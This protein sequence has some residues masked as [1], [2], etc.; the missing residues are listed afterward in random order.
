MNN[1][2]L[3]G[4]LLS[5]S[6]LCLGC[7]GFGTARTAEES[8]A[9]LDSFTAL[10]GNFIDTAAIYGKWE[11]DGLSHSELTI[12]KWLKRRGSADGINVCTK[13]AHPELA[14]M[15]VPRMSR[16]DIESDVDDSLRHLGV[17]RISLLLLHRD[18]EE[19]PVEDILESLTAMVSAGKVAHFGCS[20]WKPGRMREM[21]EAAR[22]AD[23]AG[24]SANQVMWSLAGHD[25]DAIPH[26][27]CAM[28][29]GTYAFH[30]EASLT[31]MCYS[32]QARGYFPKLALGGADALDE[33]VRRTY[34]AERNAGIARI[35]GEVSAQT[36]HTVGALALAY[37]TCQTDFPAVPV[38]GS[39][40]TEQLEEC[41]ASAEIAL[42]EEIMDELHKLNIK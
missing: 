22:R 35:L 16:Q 34:P 31:A 2:T 36:G 29:A 38:F 41:M 12:G 7:G 33:G 17:E 19:R 14:S 37:L 20:N 32:A 5:V 15:N 25:P 3:P 21:R 4:T 28:D 27:Q 30:K 9:L 24:F 13:C 1:I 40:T 6:P 26:G 23:V 10:G 18:E 42:D 8:F 39:R 11:P